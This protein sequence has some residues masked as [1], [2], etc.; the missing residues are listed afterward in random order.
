MLKTDFDGHSL[1]VLPL[2]VYGDPP[3]ARV[4]AGKLHYLGGALPLRNEAKEQ[5]LSAELERQ[6]GLRI[7]HSERFYGQQAVQASEKLR[8]LTGVSFEGTGLDTCFVAAPLEPELRTQ[9][10]RFELA[11]RS[12][13]GD[14]GE[15][16]HAS[17]EAV[18]RAYRAG[19]SL[20]PLVEGGWA[21]L[22]AG[23]LERAGHVVADLLAAK[24]ERGELPKSALPDLARLCEAL[25]HPPPPEFA[26]LRALVHDFDAVPVCELPSDLT[27]TLRHY[28]ERGV[29]WLS[30]LS[31]AGMG[32]MLAD[33]M[34]LGK[35]LQALCV[36]KPPCLVVAPASVLYNW[37][38]EIERF[39]PVAAREPLPRAQPRARRGRRGHAHELRHA[40]AT[41]WTRSRRSAWDTVV[42]DEAQNIKN[43]DSQA[44]RAAF[45]LQARFRITL[46]GTPVENRLDELWSQFHFLNPGLLGGRG[47]FHERYGRPICGGR[48]GR[49]RPAALAAAPVPAAPAEARGREGAAAAHRGGA[50]L[51]PQRQGARA[52]RRDPR[53][54]PERDPGR[55]AGG[56]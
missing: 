9:D 46:T 4:D 41:T 44:A 8:A 33:D 21:A 25:D 47:D 31:S 42:L 43:A 7:G 52:V 53:R 29:H 1:N 35:T 28:Q 14:G 2:V 51:H 11:F 16:R 12:D 37:Q 45:E 36:V 40:C 23:F 10:G 3:C 48:H 50:A 18:L 39:R 5:K 38:R 49:R 56:R 20:V 17:A 55:A 15:I 24:G 22:P 19:E 26:G 27:A 13:A 30:F 32:A 34:G 6:L 54:H